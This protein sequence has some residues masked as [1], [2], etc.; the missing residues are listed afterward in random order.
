VIV[1]AGAAV[2]EQH[3]GPLAAAVLRDQEPPELCMAVVVFD[4]FFVQVHVH[5]GLEVVMD[6]GRILTFA[7]P[8]D[9]GGA[10]AAE[11]SARRGR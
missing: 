2:D 5:L 6:P 4:A 3:S 7:A 10:A 1:E 8:D 11:P 9:R